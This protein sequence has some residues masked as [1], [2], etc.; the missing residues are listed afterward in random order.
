M[1]QDDGKSN[2]TKDGRIYSPTNGIEKK[3]KQ[4]KCDLGPDFLAPD[5]G[6]AWAV[7]IAAGCSNV[8]Q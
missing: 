5:S 2:G 3:P 8:S 1:K 7:C 4:G 6:W